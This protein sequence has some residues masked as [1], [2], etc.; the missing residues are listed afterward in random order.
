MDTNDG[1]M[2]QM[3]GAV[4][5]GHLGNHKSREQIIQ[6][7]CWFWTKEGFRPV[8]WNVWTYASV[9]KPPQKPRASLREM[10]VGTQLDHSA[11]DILA[12]LPWC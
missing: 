5:S 8:G 6:E 7:F 9:K 2:Y 1:I 10:P 3:H 4:F 11:S 12:L